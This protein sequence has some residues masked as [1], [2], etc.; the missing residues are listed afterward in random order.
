MIA[1]RSDVTQAAVAGLARGLGDFWP[2]DLAIAFDASMLDKAERLARGNATREGSSSFLVSIFDQMK[3][4][5]RNAPN[6]QHYLSLKPLAIE[7]TVLFSDTTGMGSLNT[8]RQ[9]FQNTL[10]AAPTGDTSVLLESALDAAVR[11]A[12]SAPANGYG[13]TCDVSRYNHARSVAAVA[14]CLSVSGDGDF[15]LIGGGINGIQQFLY[16]LAS[17]G[18]AKSLR[19]RSF[20]IQLLNEA[21][22]RHVLRQIGLPITNLLYAGG[23]TFQILA[24]AALLPPDAV[25]AIRADVLSRLLTTHRA[26]LRISLEVHQFAQAQMEHFAAMRAKLDERVQQE[27]RRPFASVGA[28]ALAMHVGVALGQGDSLTGFCRVTGEE[29]DDRGQTKSDFVESLEKLGSALP[30]ATHIAFCDVPAEE[31]AVASDW[32]SALRKFGLS[33]H[34]VREDK[35]VPALPSLERTG[36]VRLARF[37]P[38]PDR[39]DLSVARKLGAQRY[40]SFYFPLAQLTPFEEDE[41]SYTRVKLFDELAADGGGLKRWAVLRMDVDNLG[42]LFSQ[43]FGARGASLARAASLSFSIRLFFEAWLPKLADAEFAPADTPEDRRNLHGKLFIQ[44]AGGDDLFVVG[45]WDAVADYALRIRQSF[46][47][48][49][50]KNPSFTLSAGVMLAPE[51]FPLYQAARLAGDAE[52][53]AKR[54]VRADGASKDAITF[55]DASV[56][57]DD[58]TRIHQRAMRLSEWCA[59][60]R[61][62]RSLLQ[63]L[64]QVHAQSDEEQ[65][66]RSDKHQNK[67]KFTRATWLAAYQLTR[68]IEMLE[69]QPRNLDVI[70]AVREMQGELMSANAPTVVNALA[71][72]WAQFLI[73]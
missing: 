13:T 28:S 68:V 17:D 9:S 7:H 66:R 42:R 43:G 21:I 51:S 18:A 10:R 16:T 11:F 24:P 3:L 60:G 67:T 19:A 61:A 23:G 65:K 40:V 63:T 73:R 41:D 26:A 37:E 70:R 55:L 49:T 34:I 57:W 4:P 30:R 32:Q 14:A 27:K 48:Y 1:H 45:K 56:G 33:V 50:G 58:Y 69:R 36:L 64:Q 5:E 15:A 71:A 52:D 22:A 72:R 47:E 53:A 2:Q 20:Y 46:A 62:P 8:L 39:D 44:Y 54:L 59:G 25:Q 6:Q 31:P 29:T 35:F 12:W 38:Q